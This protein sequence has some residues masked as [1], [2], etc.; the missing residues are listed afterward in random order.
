MADSAPANDKDRE[1]DEWWDEHNRKNEVVYRHKR[2]LR[3]V[4][5][6]TAV[7]LVLFISLSVGVYA[8]I[9]KWVLMSCVVFTIIRVLLSL[10]TRTKV[11]QV[12]KQILRSAAII[13]TIA[14][15]LV[16]LPFGTHIAF[17]YPVRRTLFE[18]GEYKI[19]Y[20]YGFPNELPAKT[21]CF[22]M[23][24][25]SNT[26]FPNDREYV[27][28]TFV[29]DSE[30]IAQILDTA[31]KAGADTFSSRKLSGRP[32]SAEDFISVFCDENGLD[33]CGLAVNTIPPDDMSG[34]GYIYAVSETTGLC[35]IHWER[36][37]FY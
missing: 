5:I 19:G 6:V 34:T 31:Q 8:N 36:N 27:T 22:S 3:T 28:L 7:V 13:I 37:L 14:Y 21:D 24:F 17:M 1:F 30:G 20:L 15:A 12:C 32:E 26:I 35:V 18:V 9:T 23:K 11:K 29:T 2:L 16:L 33:I 10:G 4:D 25:V